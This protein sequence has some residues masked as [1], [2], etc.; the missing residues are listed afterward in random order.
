M[1]WC[2]PHNTVN[3]SHP[4]NTEATWQHKNT[5]SKSELLAQLD[6]VLAALA[7]NDH[8]SWLLGR[9][10]LVA[11]SRSTIY[12]GRLTTIWLQRQSCFISHPY[13]WY[14]LEA[15]TVPASSFSHRCHN[16]N[17]HSNTSLSIAQHR[18][19]SFFHRCPAKLSAKPLLGYMLNIITVFSPHSLSKGLLA[20]L[21]TRILPRRFVSH[22]YLITNSDPLTTIFK[23]WTHA[24]IVSA[25]NTGISPR[26]SPTM[27]CIVR[28]HHVCTSQLAR[29]T[30]LKIIYKQP[31]QIGLSEVKKKK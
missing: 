12:L 22:P 27:T 6:S 20:A 18:C 24:K 25:S 19:N 28:G 4:I 30:R 23:Y 29:L 10:T 8:A 1:V 15:W 11:T 26:F 21:Y 31:I 7:Y 17:F 16:L 9:F 2:S 13:K 14:K 3:I 5:W